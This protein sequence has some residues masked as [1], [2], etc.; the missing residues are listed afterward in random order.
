MTFAYGASPSPLSGFFQSPHMMRAM[1]ASNRGVSGPPDS[2]ATRKARP[3]TAT[4]KPAARAAHFFAVSLTTR[5]Y[6]DEKKGSSFSHPLP[7]VNRAVS[8]GP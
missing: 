1:P 3:T 2:P 8:S 7:R 6:P 4:L 5:F